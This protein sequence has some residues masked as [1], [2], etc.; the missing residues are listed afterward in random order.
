MHIPTPTPPL[1]IVCCVPPGPSL[2]ILK[3]RRLDLFHTFLILSQASY[4]FLL[5]L[6]LLLPCACVFFF[7]L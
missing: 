3:P 7:L 5:F 1:C 2:S 6:L 4:P